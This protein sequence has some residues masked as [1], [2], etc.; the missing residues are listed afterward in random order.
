[1][2]FEL[3]EVAEKFAELQEKGVDV[4]DLNRPLSRGGDAAGLDDGSLTNSISSYA[5][6]KFPPETE[7]S[8]EMRKKRQAEARMIQN[9]SRKRM[10]YMKWFNMKMELTS[11]AGV[12]MALSGTP[13]GMTGF[14]L[15]PSTNT[16]YYWTVK[17]TGEWLQMFEEMPFD[18]YK[19]LEAKLRK[20]ISKAGTDNLDTVFVQ[21]PSSK[22]EEGGNGYYVNHKGK[23][24]FYYKDEG[25]G[26]M[27]L[28]GEK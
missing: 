19:K 17:E 15:N 18:N 28:S 9:C 25:T 24:G 7:Y 11:K 27:V 22:G 23:A 26:Q 2:K 14:Y 8:I 5:V 13:Q 16:V 3:A 21:V 6:Q 4:G 1:M 20:E 10:S 12:M